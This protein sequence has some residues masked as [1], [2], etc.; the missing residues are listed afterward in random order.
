M[1]LD[2][3]PCLTHT[4]EPHCY[5]FLH[6]HCWKGSYFLIVSF[7]SLSAQLSQAESHIL[8]SWVS[9]DIPC[10][11]IQYNVII[12][13][14]PIWALQ[15]SFLEISLTGTSLSF[16]SEWKALAFPQEICTDPCDIFRLSEWVRGSKWQEIYSDSWFPNLPHSLCLDLQLNLF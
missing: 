6:C 15:W 16:V 5:I 4:R 8:I 11:S 7:C 2:W 9:L 3:L 14:G 12:L 13:G 1:S 10:I